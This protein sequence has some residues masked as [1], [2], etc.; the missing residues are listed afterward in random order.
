MAQ[1]S[2]GRQSSTSQPAR[3]LSIGSI[4]IPVWLP[5]IAVVLVGLALRLY[6][7]TH[8]SLWVD[9][10]YTV[11][12]ARLPWDEVL[13]LRGAY[14]NHPPLYYA[15]VKAFAL[16]FSEP[17]AA[18]AF[19]VITGTATIVVLFLMVRRLV[20]YPAAVLSSL[21]LALSPLHVWYSQD[22][23][24]YAPTVF[25]VCL[26][27][28]ALLRFLEKPRSVP[29]GVAYALTLLL[30]MFM[31][32]S[33]LYGLAP[34][35]ALVGYLSW[36]A[37]Q[38]P[39][40]WL[41]AGGAAGLLYL[42]WAFELVRTIVDIPGTR[43]FLHV[44]RTKI[45]ESTLTVLGLP[46]Q[47]SYYWGDVMTPWREW[48]QLRP[49]AVAIVAG[50]IFLSAA[51]LCGRYR[52]AF[53]TG[54]SVLAGT[55]ATA[56][57]LSYL[58]SPGYADRTVTFAV[59]GWA[60]LAGSAPFGRVPNG[61]RTI[62]LTALAIIVALSSVTLTNIYREAQK[63]PYKSAAA[64]AADGAM[65]GFPVYADE[66][67]GTAVTAYHEDVT[68]RRPTEFG[69][70]PAL[71]HAYGDYEWTAVE[72]EAIAERLDDL[73]FQRVLH[74][75]FE[76]PVSRA[77]TVDLWVR[78][79]ASLGTAIPVPAFPEGLSRVGGD[80][81]WRL[82]SS[83]IE[84]IAG[85][86]T[87][88]ELVIYGNSQAENPARLAQLAKPN[89]LYL[90]G[91]DYWVEIPAVSVAAITLQCMSADEGSL[92]E[93]TTFLTGGP[94]TTAGWQRSRVG[95]ICPEETAWLDI[96]L[97]NAAVGELRFRNIRLSEISPIG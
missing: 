28:Y 80:A 57:I 65:H 39:K 41:I 95:V 86:S 58:V 60:I 19:S 46:G 81:G 74:Q 48:E 38:I 92:L 35:I 14:D 13:G 42:P 82:L 8:Y 3:R 73:G 32:Y 17:M 54:L 44:T 9:E 53:I 90:V 91:L 31:D 11:E 83:E 25:A 21:L 59:L 30:A 93:Q 24:M 79:S 96:S 1:I 15:I 12:Y 23:R 75:R 67:M 84:V 63:E 18:R 37:R 52:L 36:R 70:S 61:A 10:V 40:T 62:S 20:N 50:L 66:F 68:V 94:L 51:T 78:E 88:Q 27:Y 34:Q 87:A 43:D 72:N 64:A 26:S 22:G 2:L 6:Q 85:T 47:G 76:D 56:A 77:P 33:A 4:P 45:Y 89:H 7:V 29:W 16:V 97:S 69:R 55:I 71:I 49:A 5:P